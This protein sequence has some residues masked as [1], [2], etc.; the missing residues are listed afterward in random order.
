[1][2]KHTK[3]PWITEGG[4]SDDPDPRWQIVSETEQI[5]LAVTC[6][7]NDRANAEFI[8]RACN[9]HDALVEACSKLANIAEIT[10]FCTG[11]WTEKHRVLAAEYAEQGRAVLALAEVKK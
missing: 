3:L 9:S 11:T 8:T 6:G 2:A 7:G 4:A 5:I 10:A 1:M